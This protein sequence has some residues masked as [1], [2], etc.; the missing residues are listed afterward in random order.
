MK[1]GFLS[2]ILLLSCLPFVAQGQ[3]AVPF[4][5]NFDTQA[6]FNQFTVIDANNDGCTWSWCESSNSFAWT[7]FSS[8]AMDDWLVTPGI[9]VS[10]GKH[11]VFSFVTR[12]ATSSFPERME[13]KYGNAA[14]AAALTESLV[15]KTVLTSSDYQRFTREIEASEDGVL[16]FGIHSISDANMFRTY[17]DSVSVT[18]GTETTSPDSV[19]SLTIT[20][21][22]DGALQAR[23]SFVAPSKSIGGEALEAVD[24]AVI[25]RN[26]NKIAS[27]KNVAQGKD[28]VYT[29]EAVPSSGYYSYEVAAYNKSGKGLSANRRLWVG[30]DTPKAPQD[31]VLTEKGNNFMVEW[32]S[33][34]GYGIHGGPVNPS[35][36][37][38]DVWKLNGTDT[39]SVGS[40]AGAESLEV[41]NTVDAATQ[42]LQR[43]FVSARNATG[44]STKAASNYFV[45][46][47]PY[48]LPFYETFPGAKPEHFFWVD[49]DHV[50]GSTHF[51]YW[52]AGDGDDGSAAYW[53]YYGKASSSLNTGRI[54]IGKAVHPAIIYRYEC[55]GGINEQL[56]V[57]IQDPLGVS[58]TIQTVDFQDIPAGQ[59]WHTG[60]VSVPQQYTNDDYVL[61]KFCVD[62]DIP[63]DY[64]GLHIDNIRVENISGNDIAVSVDGPV[65]IAKGRTGNITVHVAN[66]GDNDVERYRLRLLEGDKV[67]AETSVPEPLK[68]YSDADVI[69]EYRPDVILASDSATLTVEAVIEGADDE[70]PADNTA[71]LK[72]MFSNQE[73]ST[74]SNLTAA[75]SGESSVVLNW[76]APE[77]STQLMTEDFEGYEPW[78]PDTIGDWTSR[79]GDKANVYG[80][81]GGFKY[82][83]YDEPWG[84]MVFNPSK[85]EDQGTATEAQFGAR[86][87]SQYAAAVYSRDPWKTTYA[88]QDNWLISPELPG[89][90]QEISLWAASRKNFNET[91][92]I[93]YSVTDTALT[94]FT[95]I[96]DTHKLTTGGWENV[97]EQLPAGTKFFAIHH[98]TIADDAYLF[99]V[100]DITYTAKGA[101]VKGYNVYVDGTL[102]DTVEAT[103]ANVSVDGCMNHE[104]AVTVVYADGS[105]SLPV[106]A[107]KATGISALRLGNA[108]V[109]IYTLDGIQISTMRKGV[110]IVKMADGSTRKVVVK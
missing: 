78:I 98:N 81:Y 14:T 24:S 29:D 9:K 33:V 7:K 19:S 6:E 52:T 51:D 11:Y 62:A 88:D 90:E 59:E 71:V 64:A 44:T 108:I 4:E 66:N 53:V 103:Q 72:V 18:A 85:A 100:D 38:Y 75:A 60:K 58:D 68:S 86:S 26:G 25:S 10:A 1:K 47:N 99:R 48:T 87:G 30:L 82:P 55:K 35:S 49:W 77:V 36:V 110:N 69:M 70:N 45:T 8:Q 37:V 95:K 74:V 84:F 92:D 109:G 23:I 20:P 15:D 73:L 34:P 61:V 54:A 40:A 5:C 80:L 102:Y 22:G 41:E 67:C 57:V 31:V 94:S 83:H 76:N 32:E 13:V 56:H 101:E 79:D 65:V 2:S 89:V 43:F 17:V 105:E 96:G 93:L 91:F 63:N 106:T 42:T 97:T 50:Y 46:D 107:S 104:F 21:A 3:Q 39:L 28:V 12:A 27:I 16:Y